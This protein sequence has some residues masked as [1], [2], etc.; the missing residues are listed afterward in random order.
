MASTFKFSETNSAKVKEKIMTE[1]EQK[2][3]LITLSRILYKEGFLDSFGHISVRIP[4]KNYYYVTPGGPAGK[5]NFEVKDLVCMN[6]QNQRL[7]ENGL[8][9]MEAII[10]TVFHR[11]RDDAECIIHVHPYFSRLLTIAD[12]K[13][14]PVTLQAAIFGNNLPVYQPAEL[15]ITEEQ[16]V[17]LARV[18]GRAK[19]VLL[20]GHGVV[21]I[22]ASI[23]E[24]FYLTYYLEE[25]A[26]LLI[27]AT[28][29][30]KVIPL[31]AEESLKRLDYSAKR[32]PK[33][34]PYAKV[35]SYHEFKTRSS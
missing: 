7:S 17:N 6:Y 32:D 28:R 1:A 26:Q 4:E 33:V 21:V 3:K 11:T 12:I 14:Q 8:A 34:S 29:L 35:W 30:G 31:S 20:R 13:F 24:A 10:H 5:G 2:D 15:V 9:P 23:E 16:G 27:D 25:S 22:G 18:G 19:A